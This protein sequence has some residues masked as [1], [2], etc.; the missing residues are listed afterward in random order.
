[1][2][3]EDALDEPLHVLL[4][5]TG[6]VEAIAGRADTKIVVRLSRSWRQPV[7]DGFFGDRLQQSVTSQ[8]SLK[9]SGQVE[10]IEPLENLNQLCSRLR[11][12]HKVPQITSPRFN[13]PWSR[14][15]S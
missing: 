11:G 4:V 8:A 6:P 13:R 1:M 10:Q 5:G 3:A 14:V 15:R 7:L 2:S 9:R 12:P